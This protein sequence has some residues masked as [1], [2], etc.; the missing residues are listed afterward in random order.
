M[1][2]DRDG[3]IIVDSH[4][5]SDPERVELLPGA[6]DSIARLNST[7]MPVLLVTNQSGI[8]RGMFNVADFERVQERLS[9]ILQANGA[10]LDDVY[11]CPHAPDDDCQCRK[12]APALFQ[13]AAR[14]H[15]VDLAS[16]FFVGDRIRDIR[17]GVEV[18]G[19]GF[20]IRGNREDDS[21]GTPAGVIE[22]GT[23]GEAV[24]VILTRIGSD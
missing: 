14:E 4:Y 19:T 12:P 24:D 16:S 7:G 10:H 17:P 23:L 6:A 2:L 9:D 22:V 18:G 5:L 1:F 20:L 3:T 21:V 8:G 13:R 11:V 15:G